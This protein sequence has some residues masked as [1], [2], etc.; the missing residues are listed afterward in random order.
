MKKKR[1]FLEIKQYQLEDMLQAEVI[2]LYHETERVWYY[3]SIYGNMYSQNKSTKRIIQMRPA[4]DGEGYLQCHCGNK[5]M[6]IHI[7]VAETF[8]R[9]RKPGE[10]INHLN[11]DRT[12]NVVD[13][14][15]ITTQSDNLKHSWDYSKKRR[16]LTYE[17]AKQIRMLHSTEQLSF[18][19]LARKFN[20][21][22]TSVKQIIENQTY[23]PEKYENKET[24]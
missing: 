2:K 9:P 10:V 6:R 7:A 12:C 14:L 23:K 4:P 20:C 17:Q 13:N 15:V 21:S 11:S 8:I 3:I 1:T 16:K 5:H 19:A 22:A 18:N 24:K